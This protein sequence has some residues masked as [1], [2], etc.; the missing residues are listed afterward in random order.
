MELGRLA[1]GRGNPDVGLT[2]GGGFEVS[3][4]GT[5]LTFDGTPYEGLEVKVDEVPV[6]LLMSIAENYTALTGGNVDVQTG[7]KIF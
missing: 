1:R 3:G 6:G 7:M 2:A 5:I 4:T